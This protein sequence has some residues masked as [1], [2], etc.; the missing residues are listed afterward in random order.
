MPGAKV[1]LVHQPQQTLLPEQ[2]LS[3]R[4][5]VMYLSDVALLG[6]EWSIWMMEG[7]SFWVF[8]V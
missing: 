2:I 7:V 6:D 4:F 5:S 3:L 1:C 8:H